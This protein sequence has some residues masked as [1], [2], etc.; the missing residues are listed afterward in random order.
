MGNKIDYIIPSKAAIVDVSYNKIY[1]LRSQLMRI[2]NLLSLRGGD[3]LDP[4]TNRASSGK[5]RESSA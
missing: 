4:C 1:R 5:G 3:V 2:S